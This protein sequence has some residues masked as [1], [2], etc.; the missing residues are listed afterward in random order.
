MDVSVL[1]LDWDLNVTSP[2]KGQLQ[3][4]LTIRCLIRNGWPFVGIRSLLL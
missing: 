3:R 4:W 2:R 1:L